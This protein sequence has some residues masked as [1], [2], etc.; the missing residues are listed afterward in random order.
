MIFGNTIKFSLLA[1]I[2]ISIISYIL[3]SITYFTFRIFNIA[4]HNSSFDELSEHIALLG[5]F[6]LIIAP[7]LLWTAKNKIII[8]EGG[9]HIYSFSKL[10]QS[11]P[12]TDISHLSESWKRPL[13]RI[14][15]HNKTFVAIP[16]M[17][18]L[19]LKKLKSYI[20]STKMQNKAA[21]TN[22]LHAE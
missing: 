22:P 10:K 8:S 13:Y 9:L 6:F 19:Q 2:L 15:L 18:I 17:S 5:L 14:N 16:S 21:H 20:E 7:L 11:I 4:P 3:V 12:L 1:S